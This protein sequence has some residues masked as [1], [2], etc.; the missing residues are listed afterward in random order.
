VGSCFRTQ[1]RREIIIF[2][3]LICWA[4]RLL[5][6][7]TVDPSN[8]LMF[9]DVERGSPHA[10]AIGVLGRTRVLSGDASGR[11]HPESA[12]SRGDLALAL[13]SALR[14]NVNNP[15]PDMP[16]YADL[17]DRPALIKAALAVASAR[18]VLPRSANEFGPQDHVTR[19]ELANA[20]AQAFRLSA[21]PAEKFSA[22]KENTAPR[23]QLSL[24]IDKVISAGFM[25]PRDDGEFASDE[26]VSRAEAAGALYAALSAE[27]RR[28]ERESINTPF[29]NSSDRNGSS[30]KPTEHPTFKAR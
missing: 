13:A 15:I 14:L 4:G 8:L 21:G 10:R 7:Y 6:V 30:S 22:S 19:G 23:K 27:V 1:P 26:A 25:R 29:I 12:L 5:D 3:D 18:M 28:R 9:A 17:S 16:R 11:F 24:A 2:S 20:L